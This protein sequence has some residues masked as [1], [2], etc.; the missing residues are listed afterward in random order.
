MEME[1]T[2][3][4]RRE[5]KET[6]VG[7]E[8]NM[9]DSGGSKALGTRHWALGEGRK[10]GHQASGTRKVSS[11]QRGRE[12]SEEKGEQERRRREKA[13]RETH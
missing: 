4:R 9:G 7:D 1:E 13:G 11:T 8:R 12:R 3:R 10:A 6:R 2:L 5:P